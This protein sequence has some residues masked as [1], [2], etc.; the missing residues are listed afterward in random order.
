MSENTIDSENMDKRAPDTA[1]PKG[2]R[3]PGKKNKAARR[4]GESSP[5]SE[6]SNGVRYNFH[7]VEI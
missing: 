4:C 7:T 6:G 2:T 1:K 3:K 5:F